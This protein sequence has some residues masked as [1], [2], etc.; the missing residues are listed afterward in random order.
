MIYP[1]LKIILKNDGIIEL[2]PQLGHAILLSE[3]GA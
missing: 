3:K 1:N 2:R